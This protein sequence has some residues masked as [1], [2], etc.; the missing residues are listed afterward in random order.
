MADPAS[1]IAGRF[2]NLKERQF[3]F[4]QDRADVTDAL[5][6]QKQA[7]D[8][9]LAE[10]TMAI[11]GTKLQ[12]ETQQALDT[13]DFLKHF[14]N[15]QHTDPHYEDKIAQLAATYPLA[16]ADK[17]VQTVLDIRN[18]AR[19]T[20]QDATKQGGAYE[21]PEGPA[22]DTFHKTFAAT[23]DLNAARAGAKATSENEKALRDAVSQGYLTAADF[24][25]PEGQPLPQIYNQ[26]GS[27]NY[28]HA[29]DIAAQ[30]AGQTTGKV[31]RA[32][33]MDLKTAQTYVQ[34]YLRDSGKMLEEDPNAKELYGLYS[35]KLL[36]NARKG[37]AAA[38][39]QPGS[40]PA[41]Q[42]ESPGTAPTGA[43]PTLTAT[44]NNV[45]SQADYEALPPGATFLFNGKLGRKP[46]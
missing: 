14:Q 12:H 26:D 39:A 6:Q 35:Q 32:E 2:G 37:A 21:F 18:T 27:L 22:R 7:R 25:H 43:A 4:T 16:G 11:E 38:A 13:A 24:A 33:D 9:A 45:A 29:Q 31:A 8:Q 23:G 5:N 41:T 44:P 17:S 10:K 46:K 28:Q 19:K 3:Q 1:T 20:Y 40:T 30:R 42:P 36:D 34:S 15:V